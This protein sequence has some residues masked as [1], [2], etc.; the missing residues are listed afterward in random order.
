MKDF[1]QENALYF[2]FG[3]LVD[4]PQYPLGLE[5][6]MEDVAT[7]IISEYNNNKAIRAQTKLRREFNVDNIATRQLLPAIA[8]IYATGAL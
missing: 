1:G 4:D 3:S 7:L 2:R 5:K 6:Y 8:E